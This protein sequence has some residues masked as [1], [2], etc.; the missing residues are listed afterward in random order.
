MR[1]EN[2][3]RVVNSI[4]LLALALVAGAAQPPEPATQPAEARASLRLLPKTKGDGRG[5]VDAL[6]AQ[7]WINGG[8]RDILG[9][10]SD[11]VLAFRRDGEQKLVLDRVTRRYRS[12]NDGGAGKWGERFDEKKQTDPA[13]VDGPVLRVGEQQQTF[14]VVPG[15]ELVLNALVP[16]DGKWYYAARQLWGKGEHRDEEVLLDFADDPLKANTGKG[17]IR[18][19][20][21]NQGRV[22]ED[23]VTFTLLRADKQGRM[24]RVVSDDPQSRARWAEILFAPDRKYGLMLDKPNLNSLVFT[25]A[26][27]GER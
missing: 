24:I 14:V 9:R 6:V 1:H 16:I 25:A 23:K 5:Q 8:M 27:K 26:G 11:T 7:A 12:V 15:K 18:M 17:T 20:N 19:C 21:G 22:L 10:G 4:A 2:R 13:E 3:V